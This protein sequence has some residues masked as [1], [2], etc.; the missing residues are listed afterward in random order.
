MQHIRV[1]ISSPADVSE[2]RAALRKIL[3]DL[4]YDPFLR[5]RVT[6]EE[7]TWDRPR[8]EVPLLASFSPQEAINRGLPRPSE[9]D[10]VIVLIWGRLGTPLGPEYR[11]PDGGSVRSGTEWEYL[12]AIAGEASTGRPRVLLYRRDSDVQ[13]SLNDPELSEKREQ[14]ELAKAFFAEAMGR[15]GSSP[16]GVNLYSDIQGFTPLVE[17]HLRT[18]V[19]QIM[20]ENMDVDANPDPRRDLLSSPFPGLRPF[21]EEESLVFFGREHETSEIIQQISNPRFRFLAVIG[22]SGVG[23][24]SL[25]NAGVIPALRAGA[26][27]GADSWPIVRFTPAE[28]EGNP[29]L[30]LVT[31]VAEVSGADTD[32]PHV[33]ADQLA[34]EPRRFG[35][36]V[37]LALRGSPPWARL[38]IFIDQF[39]ELFAS[40]ITEE[41]RKTFI[42]LVVESV[43]S[44]RVVAVATL[45]VDFYAHCLQDPELVTLLRGGSF[46]LSAAGPGALYKMITRPAE[47]AGLRFEDRLAER[48]L[49]DAGAEPGSLALMAFTLNLICQRASDQG[50]LLVSEYD[51][52]GGIRGAIATRAEEIFDHLDASDRKHIPVLFR[53]LTDVS[54]S[55][56]PVRRRAR[57][58]SLSRGRSVERLIR[59][60]THAR[61]V[62][63]SDDD[64]RE[65]MVEVAHEALFSTWPRLAEWIQQTQDDMTLLRQLRRAALDWDLAHRP[66]S[67]LWPHER[68]VVVEAM[69]RNLDPEIDQVIEEFIVPESTRILTEADDACTH[70]R[71]ASIGDRLAEIGYTR[72]GQGLDATGLPEFL[73]RTVPGGEI[74]L[75]EAG[76]REVPELEISAYPVTYRQFKAFLDAPDGFANDVWFAGLAMRPDQPGMQFR[77]IENHPADNVAWFDAVAFS[78]WLSARSGVEVRLPAD[79]E[80]QLAASGPGDGSRYAWGNGWNDDNANTIECG[81]GRTVAVGLYGAGATRDGVHDLHGNVWEWCLNTLSDTSVERTDFAAEG[82]RVVR[83]GSWLVARSFARANFRGWDDPELRYPALGFRLVRAASQGSAHRLDHDH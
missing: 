35:E 47:I 51:R 2:E 50:E 4:Q 18:V 77:R 56:T 53:R 72:P 67:F 69:L 5:G 83:G 17:A 42:K 3:A 70:Q 21:S 61:L 63:V 60:L 68:L 19:K 64:Q 78:R 59:L 66:N 20:D 24:S 15:T 41:H 74:V 39:E 12:D 58:S 16:I 23:K 40:E 82:A 33:T 27:P 8:A 7:V 62:V 6:V 28:I 45:R 80:W 46:P 31:R 81:L 36:F 13:V 9:C 52:I 43:T 14:L 71:R 48:I 10:V 44:D 37:E 29:F 34:R 57:L 65:P 49:D 32:E 76:K 55:G 75:R 30:G 25:I 54:E 22:A 73:W 26:V 38:L 11:R 79:W 1:F